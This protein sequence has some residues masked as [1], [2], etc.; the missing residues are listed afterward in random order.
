MSMACS[1]FGQY[2]RCRLVKSLLCGY[3]GT[4]RAEKSMYT[5]ICTN[6]TKNAVDFIREGFPPTK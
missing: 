3:W 2:C 4:D 6:K 5:D 1:V